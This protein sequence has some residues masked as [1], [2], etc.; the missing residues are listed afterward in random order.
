[1]SNPIL[2]VKK[3]QIGGNP[4]DHV[5]VESRKPLQPWVAKMIEGVNPYYAEREV[6]LQISKAITIKGKITAPRMSLTIPLSEVY[7]T[8]LPVTLAVAERTYYTPN[9]DPEGIGEIENKHQILFRTPEGVKFL[10]FLMSAKRRPEF[11]IA[12][13][14]LK[15]YISSRPRQERQFIMKALYEDLM[16]YANRSGFDLLKLKSQALAR[17]IV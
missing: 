8:C 12:Y 6:D 5:V 15:G 2:G 7:V 17:A 14:R 1:M 3:V 10:K 16:A 4:W 11:Q 9:P 13:D